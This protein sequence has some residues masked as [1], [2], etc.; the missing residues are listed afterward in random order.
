MLR[1]YGI[2]IEDE[3]FIV[4]GGAIKLTRKMEGTRFE[5]ELRNLARVKA[6]LKAE[7]I[8]DKQGLE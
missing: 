7:G 2:E 3:C 1:I 6:F 4:T 8:T 5:V